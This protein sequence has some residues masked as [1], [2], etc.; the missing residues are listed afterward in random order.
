MQIDEEELSGAITR[1]SAAVKRPGE[2][3]GAPASEDQINR[4]LALVVSTAQL[5]CSRTD[6]RRLQLNSAM[7]VSE[8]IGKC[9]TVVVLERPDGTRILEYE[10][11][12]SEMARETME[13]IRISAHHGRIYLAAIVAEVTSGGAMIGREIW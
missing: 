8:L 7:K 11:G 13:Q 10:P 9:P 1:L 6:L 5:A 12:L 4:D 2:P 3:V